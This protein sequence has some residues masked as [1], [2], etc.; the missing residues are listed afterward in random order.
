VDITI[1]IKRSM[2]DDELP[3]YYDIQEISSAFEGYQPIVNHQ[4][5]EGYPS[6]GLASVLIQYS[7]TAANEI[8][9]S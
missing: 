1:L 2:T 3:E 8:D 4:T 7:N 6:P 9:N 5:S